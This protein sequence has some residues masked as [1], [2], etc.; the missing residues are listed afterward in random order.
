MHSAAATY[1]PT[2]PEKRL[3]RDLHELTRNVFFSQQNED[4][5]K[6]IAKQHDAF[7]PKQFNTKDFNDMNNLA[8]EIESYIH[9]DGAF[10][11]QHRQEIF[12]KINTYGCI[13]DNKLSL[14]KQ[15]TGGNP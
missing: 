6:A 10:K 7:N 1:S 13:L 11:K 4:R 3:S 8:V 15:N 9:K 5:I 12:N 14:I 2:P